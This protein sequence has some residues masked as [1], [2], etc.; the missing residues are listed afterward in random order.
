MVEVDEEDW[1]LYRYVSEQSARR[2]TDSVGFGSVAPE[3]ALASGGVG[4]DLD[5]ED[6]NQKETQSSQHSRKQRGLSYSV[7]RRSGWF[8]RRIFGSKRHE[9]KF[10]CRQ[11]KLNALG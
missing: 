8:G 4:K 3:I 5:H 2:S 10:L 6:K 11:L 9:V 7:A 1:M